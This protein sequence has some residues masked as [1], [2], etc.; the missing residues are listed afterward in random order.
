MVLKPGIVQILRLYNQDVEWQPNFLNDIIM[1]VAIVGAHGQ[2]GQL[3]I[4][5]MSKDENFEPTAIIRKPEQKEVFDQTNTPVI[6]TDLEKSVQELAGMIKGFDAIIFTSGSGA[7]T[8]PD[9]TLLIVLYVY[10]KIIEV[11]DKNV[12]NGCVMFSAI[13]R[14]S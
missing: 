14:K 6:L 1:K 11:S 7:S 10:V 2:I 13:D 12:I 9:K 8:G 3:L 4:K 5:K